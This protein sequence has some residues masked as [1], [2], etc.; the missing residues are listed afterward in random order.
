MKRSL[1]ISLAV[2]DRNE[3]IIICPR[4][5]GGEGDSEPEMSH[6]FQFSSFPGLDAQPN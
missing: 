3:R 2:V 1:A 6:A 4:E 5:C